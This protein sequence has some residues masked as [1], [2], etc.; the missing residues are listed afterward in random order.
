MRQRPRAPIGAEELKDVIL[1]AI[2][3]KFDGRALS[4]DIAEQALSLAAFE[5][6]QMA[7][8]QC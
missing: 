7:L 1:H 5:I 2:V 6:E 3:E 4:W 8:M